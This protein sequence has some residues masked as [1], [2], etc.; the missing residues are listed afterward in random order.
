MVKNNDQ[1]WIVY[2]STFPPRECGIATFTQDLTNAIDS[3]FSPRIKTKIIA[4]N[5]SKSDVQVYPSKV[6]YEIDQT[7]ENSYLHAAQKI[8]SQKQIKLVNIQ[9]EY[10][11][12]GGKWGSNILTFLKAV[13]KPIVITM[14]T[15]PPTPDPDLLKLTKKMLEM[16]NKI[17]V[18]THQAKTILIERYGIDPEKINVI[19]H[20]IHPVIFTLPSQMKSKLGFKKRIIL[21]TFGLL[22][23]NKGV[24]YVI[25]AL[26]EIVK[27][28]P[29]ILYL[30]IGQTHPVVR[31]QEGE[32][33]RRELLKLVK[34]LKLTENVKFFDRYLSLSDIIKFLQA[35]DIYIST[36]LDPNQTVSGTLSYALGTGR[37]IVSTAFSQAK[38]II[39]ENTGL[40]VDF[41]NP[42]EYSRAILRL[43]KDT[44]TRENM[45]FCAYSS[46]R[47]ML[48]SNV[49]IS[50]VNL[51]SSIAPQIS[52]ENRNLPPVNLDHL[53]RMTDSFGLFQFARLSKPDPRYGYTIDDNA[54]A[55]IV[56]AKYYQ[57]TCNRPA[58]TLI[59]TYLNFIEQCQI[60]GYFLNYVNYQQEFENEANSAVDLSDSNGR[61][62]WALSELI[63][64]TKIPKKIKTKAIHLLQKWINNYTSYNSARAN[65]FII[66]GLSLLKP[67]HKITG[68]KE[69]IE[70]ASSF[71]YSLY[72]KNSEKEWQW[73][74]DT[75]TYANGILPEALFLAYSVNKNKEFLYIAEESLN[76]LINNSFQ[77]PIY[78]PIGQKQWYKK[79]QTREIYDQQPEDVTAMVQALKTAHKITKKR[80]YLNLLSKTFYWFLGNNLLGE[81]I[82]DRKTGGSYDGLTPEGVNLHQGA[83]STVSY[84][85]AR[86]TIGLK[87]T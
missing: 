34:K 40:L 55:L 16:V 3:T 81:Q 8:N 47:H 48:W 27:Q 49:A 60:N 11:I 73:F 63:V 12:H 26:P 66:K 41:K 82:Y 33:Y 59:Q 68:Y 43:L 7:D 39:N 77:G 58:L 9:H 70:S 23:R 75:L 78:V 56:A 13:K 61:T 85:L 6:I 57:E 44:P 17:V 84:L 35:T 46:T 50:Y 72:Q 14:H 31:R 52:A 69:I 30:A 1:A 19:P 32:S 64:K 18:L 51:F 20:G 54:R 86:L 22:S 10:G 67:R 4:L 38:E 42:K 24:E 87:Y 79:G 15:V 37:C 76:F 5:T 28:Y 62:V 21:S 36:S 71:L 83:E 65:A 2:L 80:K 53:R 29:N 45:Y 25:K 74:E